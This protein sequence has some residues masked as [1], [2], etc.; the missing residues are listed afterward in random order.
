MKPRYV[1]IDCERF[2]VNDNL[3]FQHTG[4]S[5]PDKMLLGNAVCPPVAA[6][7]LRRL[8]S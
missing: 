1:Y 2:M 4:I 7:L 5:H 6:Q 8:A 3:G